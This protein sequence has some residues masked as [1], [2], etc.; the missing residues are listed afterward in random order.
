MSAFCRNVPLTALLKIR[1]LEPV[2][3]FYLVG[4]ITA[5]INIPCML[6]VTRIVSLS[7]HSCVDFEWG[8]PKDGSN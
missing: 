8:K 7:S 1:N 4:I 5:S 6:L 2:V 3:L